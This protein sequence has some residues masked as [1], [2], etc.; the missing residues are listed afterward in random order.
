MVKATAID[1]AV[2][3]MGTVLVL[4]AGSTRTVPMLPN[5][6]KFRSSCMFPND[7]FLSTIEF[8]WK[9]KYVPNVRFVKK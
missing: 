5:W 1:Y 3:S 8:M 6:K 2:G 4:P 7:N 9:D